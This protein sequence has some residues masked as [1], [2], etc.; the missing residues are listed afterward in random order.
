MSRSARWVFAIVAV[1]A[2]LL[3]VYGLVERERSRHALEAPGTDL[4]QR[5]DRPIP[6]L[7]IQ[8]RDGS[9]SVLQSTG[10]RTLVH[11]WAT[12][13]PPC[14]AEL[15]GL[16]ELPSRQDVAVVAIALD[17]S[18]E[19][20]EAFLGDMSAA[21]VALAASEDVERS[22]RIRTLP[23]TFLVEADGQIVLR[24]DGARDWADLGFVQTHVVKHY[25]GR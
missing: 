25:S 13:C 8:R 10:R 19:D 18:W 4:P 7:D 1:Q 17:Q 21:N 16:L 15:P 24:F 20:V 23:V 9:R 14:R 5:V 12:W 22:L 3:G 2:A 6:S 11:V